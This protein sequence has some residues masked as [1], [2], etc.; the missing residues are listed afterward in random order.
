MA[1]TVIT[2]ED[3]IQI[4]LNDFAAGLGQ[5][6]KWLTRQLLRGFIFERTSTGEGTYTL[7]KLTTGVY[8][9]LSFPGSYALWFADQTTPFA[10][11]GSETYDIWARGLKAYVKT[12]SR[13][14][15]TISVTGTPVHFDR[16]MAD[17]YWYL[18]NHRSKEVAQQIGGNDYSPDAAYRACLAQHEYWKGV[19]T[20]AN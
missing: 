16:V 12:G 3:E 13:S 2:I 8:K 11:E 15:A 14:S 17:V 19:V 20:S 1:T 5:E 6:P 9:D 10:A 4:A 7:Q 18:A